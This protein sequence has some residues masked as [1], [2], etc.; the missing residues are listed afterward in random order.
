MPKIHIFI[1]LLGLSTCGVFAQ[2]FT[3]TGTLVDAKT[4]KPLEAAT[5]VVEKAKDS[6]MITYT[7]TDENGAFKL[8]GKA[9]KQKANLY[10]SFVGYAAYS[11][12]IN[13]ARKRNFKLGFLALRTD[14]NTLHDVIITARSVPVTIKKDTLEFNAGSFKTKK[15]ANVED[16][17]RE[18]PGVEIDAQGTI[19]INGKPVN[20]VLVNGKPFFGDDPTIATRNLTKEIV[21]KIQ[22][23][24]TK[25]EAQAFTGEQGDDQNKTINITIDKD[26]N[27]GV[28]GRVAAG[29]GTNKRFEYAGFANY[30]D[31]DRRISVLGGGNNINSPGFSFGEIEKIY[32]RRR[33]GDFLGGDGITNS[34]VAGANY[35]DVIGKKNDVNADYSYNASNSFEERRED[36]E[37]TL[38][39]RRFFSNSSSRTDNKDISHE[40]NARGEIHL[41][42]T[43]LIE[44]R[45]QFN[46]TEGTY[47]NKRMEE[48][49]DS[50]QNL[51]NQSSTTNES[52]RNGRNLDNRITATKRYGNGGG[53]M[54]LRMNNNINNTVTDARLISNTE[55]FGDDPSTIA[56]NQNTTGE[57]SRN[58]IGLNADWRIPIIA[59][60]FFMR[61]EY[62]YDNNRRDDRQSVFDLSQDTGGYNDFNLAQSTDFT[63][64][65]RRSR[66][67]LG[68]TFDNDKI[69]ARAS[70]AYVFRKLQ[71][72]DALRE[73]D[74]SNNFN[75]L[76][77]DA[78]FSYD[79]NKRTSFYSGYNL[80]NSAPDI[81]QLSPYI[82]VSNPLNT[83]QGNPD[84]T[85]SNQ[86]RIYI[87]FN[88]FDWQTRTGFNSF[89]NANFTNDEVVS[90]STIDETNVRTTTYTNVDGVYDLYGRVNYGKE[91]KLDTTR[92]LKYELRMG[93]RSNRNVNFNNEVEYASKSTSYEPSIG[94]RFTWEDL[95]EIRP[96]YSPSFTRNTF[97]LKRFANT[98]FTRQELRLRTLTFWP[99]ELEWENDIRFITNPNV[100]AGFQNS[101]VFWNSTLAYSVLQDQG[102]V[103]LKAYDILNQN[104]NAQRTA[105][106]DYV[107]DV[108]STVLQQYFML[109]FSYRFN[110]LGK[111]GEIRDHNGWHR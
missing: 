2:D 59:N 64:K 33:Y 107:Q 12:K 96:E 30:F 26:K 75:A 27:K 5:V 32:G 104:T 24:D 105:T 110:T 40:I 3:I 52:F 14:V 88:N 16:L 56:R 39:N 76:E 84:L 36:R 99:K 94:L 91:I 22:V 34:R 57:E 35:V 65:D 48:T 63:N 82:N 81:R 19:T 90:K 6:S 38:P 45:P 9:Y 78:N 25:T 15:D 73:I 21:E 80:D 28:F 111:K 100:A 41:D 95:F 47:R 66:P 71:S 8:K 49:R 51:T 46:Y 43:F 92:T 89:F 55:I 87:G 85:P 101:A 60:T 44:L 42:S 97:D 4:K 29:G 70:A 106:A 67:E 72:S 103:T 74:F 61:A 79:F 7:I 93:V 23:V 50:L 86:H 53:F 1:F 109:S 83:I 108:Q 77:I 54:R 31:N 98:D 102:T 69:R 58:G 37:V 62:N 17:L 68:M 11:R 10:V 18:L 20:K 13:F